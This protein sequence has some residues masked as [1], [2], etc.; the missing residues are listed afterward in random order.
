MIRE[1]AA[2][3]IARQLLTPN[4]SRAVV[5]DEIIDMAARA[6]MLA[7]E[8]D[9]QRQRMEQTTSLKDEKERS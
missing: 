7:V 9:E 4:I 3:K 5:T 1:Q 2:R 8:M 6:I